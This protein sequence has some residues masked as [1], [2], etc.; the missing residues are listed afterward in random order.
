MNVR[1]LN[2]ATQDE[3]FFSGITPREAVRNAF[4][5]SKGDKNT[6]QYAERYDHMVTEGKHSFACGDWAALKA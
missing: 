6:W 5:Y 3:M 1:V 4:A 2:L